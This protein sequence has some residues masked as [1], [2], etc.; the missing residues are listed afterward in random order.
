[1]ISVKP[2]L[3]KLIMNDFV[4]TKETKYWEIYE[5][6]R[7]KVYYCPLDDVVGAE[8]IFGEHPEKIGFLFLKDEKYRK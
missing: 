8:Y 5:V 7:R 2:N 3:C 4:K 1:M 6:G